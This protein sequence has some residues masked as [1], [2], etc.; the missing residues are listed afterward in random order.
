MTDHAPIDQPILEILNTYNPLEVKDILLCGARRKATNHKDWDSVLAYYQEYD[1]Y[2]HH[3]LLDS[4]DAWNHYAIMQKAYTMTDHT[5]DDQ[6][7]YI[8]DVF[9]LY[10]DV[11]ASDIGHKWDLHNQTRKQIEDDVLAIELQIRKDQLGVI[12]GGKS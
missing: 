1:S 6:K 2:I 11:L 8:K 10:L 7:E 9:Y 3:Y 4:P 5:Q 12:D